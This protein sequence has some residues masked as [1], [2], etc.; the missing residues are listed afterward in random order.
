MRSMV[1]A[2]MMTA[3]AAPA[4]AEGDADAG[5]DVAAEWCADCHD[6][7]PGGAMKE[8]PPSFAAIAVYRDENTMRSRILFPHM[9]MTEAAQI[10]GLNV[11]DLIAY[12]RSLEDSATGLP[13]Q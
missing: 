11:D 6:I 10:L 1:L 13:A 2:V 9:G 7:A 5:R 4:L 8:F 3:I 12:I